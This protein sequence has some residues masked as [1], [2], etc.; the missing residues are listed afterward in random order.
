[1]SL[2]RALIPSTVYPCCRS[3]E[4]QTSVQSFSTTE[5]SVLLPEFSAAMSLSLGA[6]ANAIKGHSGT[7]IRKA[8]LTIS[9]QKTLGLFIPEL[10]RHMAKGTQLLSRTQCNTVPRSNARW[11]ELDSWGSQCSKHAAGVCTSRS[12]SHSQACWTYRAQDIVGLIHV[13]S[14]AA[15]EPKQS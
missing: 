15:R 1:M 10:L 11:R 12:Q 14:P 8:S 13:Y 3:Q 2:C 5:Q 4:F 9:L 6:F 7:L